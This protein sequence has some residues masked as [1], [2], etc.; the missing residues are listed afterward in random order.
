MTHANEQR[1]RTSYYLQNIAPQLFFDE[2]NQ[3][4]SGILFDITHAIADQL[5]MQ[6]EMLAIPR[7]RIERSLENNIIDIDCIANPDWYEL[8][9]L[10]WSSVIYQNPDVLIN[11]EG[12]TSITELS[13]HNKLKIG[14]T[15]GYIYT[16]LKPYFDDK[17]IQ[18]V[19]SISAAESHKKYR[20]N[21]VSG[22]V[23]ASVEALYFS[24]KAED[25]IMPLN[26]N[27]IHC[28]LSPSM[29]K[30]TV[31]RINNAI[32]SLK[33]SGKIEAILTKYKSVAKVASHR[34][35]TITD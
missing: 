7:K 6:L 12:M 5:N 27:N 13:S 35:K 34:E 10:Q 16:E 29:D 25:S 1:L 28:V 9:T 22:F 14:T 31:Q 4:I 11:R 21:K 20:K 33:A 3:P 17:H 24:K 19:V 32:E 15:L 2:H 30:K 8:D 18:A 26:R 23:S